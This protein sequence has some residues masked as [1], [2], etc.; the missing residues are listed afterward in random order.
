MV[1][2]M[3][4]IKAIIVPDAKAVKYLF[5]GFKK[6]LYDVKPLDLMASNRI[7]DVYF[8]IPETYLDLIDN[9]KFDSIWVLGLKEGREK[10][11]IRIDAIIRTFDRQGI[12]IVD[13]DFIQHVR[14][15]P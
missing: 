13:E 10:E 6:K 3:K 5:E 1:V 14:N 11:A 9:V 8:F 7:E 2:I 15:G 4:L 12:V